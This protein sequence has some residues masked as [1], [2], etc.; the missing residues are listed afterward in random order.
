MSYN[1]FKS[2]NATH[3]RKYFF[4]IIIAG[5]IVLTA[6]FNVSAHQPMIIEGGKLAA[7]EAPEVSKAYYAELKGKPDTYRISS[8]APLKFYLNILVPDIEGATKDY[9]VKVTR[10]KMESTGTVNYDLY[11][12]DGLKADWTA[13]YEKFA[14]DAY[15]KGPEIRS[16]LEA[17]TYNIEVSSPDNTGKYV[18]AIGEK[19]EFSL[20]EAIYTIKILP[21]LKK[22]YFGKSPLTAYFNLVGLY[23]LILLILILAAGIFVWYF[24][25]MRQKDKK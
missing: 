6:P 16:D 25:R 4:L 18:L 2:D 17:G 1:T 15:F 24:A 20:S 21:V 10:E 22:D 13:F 5:L 19:E 12:L 8:E 3:M 9:A 11:Y 14:G 23:L 7:V